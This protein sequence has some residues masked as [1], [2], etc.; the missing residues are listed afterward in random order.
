MPILKVL[1]TSSRDLENHPTSILLHEESPTSDLDLI[2]FGKDEEKLNY[3][4][5][6]CCT[7]IPR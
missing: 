2:V 4:F 1:K 5:A 7:V 3:S 6:K